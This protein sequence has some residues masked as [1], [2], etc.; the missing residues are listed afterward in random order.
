MPGLYILTSKIS[1]SSV[2]H[3]VVQHTMYLVHERPV[4]K[5]LQELELAWCSV[6]W[7]HNN[8]AHA[9][10]GN[11]QDSASGHS[12]IVKS[13]GSGQCASW[14]GQCA[15][16]WDRAHLD[17][18]AVKAMPVC[19]LGATVSAYHVQN[20]LWTPT[21][22][23]WYLDVEHLGHVKPQSLYKKSSGHGAGT[24]PLQSMKPQHKLRWLAQTQIEELALLA[25]A[26]PWIDIVDGQSVNSIT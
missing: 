21:S 8:R 10:L 3:R 14:W 2:L 23:D 18:E 20:C 25:Q 12:W 11:E 26:W 7:T 17:S 22:A 5:L 19:K 16:W 6:V 9:K 1:Q 4:L 13:W 15:S 24:K